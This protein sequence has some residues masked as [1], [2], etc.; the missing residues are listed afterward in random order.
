MSRQGKEKAAEKRRARIDSV[1]P[2][3]EES[4]SAGTNLSF[5]KVVVAPAVPADEFGIG[6]PVQCFRYVTDSE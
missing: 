3:L 5:N 6:G 1:L 2:F 4:K